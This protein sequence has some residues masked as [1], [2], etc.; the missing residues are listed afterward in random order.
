LTILSCTEIDL[1]GHRSYKESAA[2]GAA[3][4]RTFLIVSDNVS[5]T[6]PNV[7]SSAT[8]VGP[9]NLPSPFDFFPGSTLARAYD[10]ETSRSKRDRRTWEVVIQYKTI[11]NQQEIDRT[12][13]ADPTARP[14][15]ITG[16]SRTVMKPVR[17][18]LR[19]PAYQTYS[20]SATFTAQT[21]SNSA[22]DPLDPPI[23]RAMT[24]WEFHCEKNVSSLPSWYAVS[25]GYGNGVNNADQAI[26]V[27]GSSYTLTKGTAKLSNLTFS[28]HKQ[29][30]NIDFLTLTWNVTVLSKITGSCDPWDEEIVDVGMRTRSS[31]LWVGITDKSG[32]YITSPI[33]FNGSGAQVAST[34]TAVPDSDLWKYAYRPNGPRVDFSAMTWT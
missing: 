7:R 28:D 11:F 21:P 1:E 5:D 20:S 33:P 14:I 29:E 19:S 9:N 26:T 4:K 12:S 8:S 27:Q 23:Q 34:G 22:G 10:F 15:K 3:G 17:Y 16:Q 25:A 31:G 32:Q 13:D 18:M 30:N 6:E 24:E 2:E